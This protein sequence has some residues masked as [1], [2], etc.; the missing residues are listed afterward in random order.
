MI[1]TIEIHSQV[2]K[3]SEHIDEI[4]GD[5]ETSRRYKPIAIDP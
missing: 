4:P 2:D 3:Q 5:F 1:D